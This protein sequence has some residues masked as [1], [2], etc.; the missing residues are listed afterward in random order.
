MSPWAR[1][2]DY[3]AVVALLLAAAAAAAGLL[4]SGL[5]RDTA[6]MVRQA[7]ATDLVTLAV[8]L[9]AL[10][11][12]LWRARSGSATARLV[13]IGALG[14]MAYSYA[15]YGFSVVINPLT[16]VHLAILGLATWALVL[17][18]FGLDQAT[19][20]RAGRIR[21][22]RRTT[23]GFLVIVTALFGLLWLGQ[24]AGAITSGKLPPS[25][26]ELNLPTSAIYALDLAFALPLLALAGGW[27]LRHDRRGP[28]SALAAL[29]WLVLL[30]LSVLAIFAID[31]AAGVSVESVPV[32]VFGVVTGVAAV[33]AVLGILSTRL[34]NAAGS[35]VESAS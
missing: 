3:L 7:R 6:E 1:V 30:G 4:G 10:G 28:A 33:L 17:T 22:P 16:P 25:V 11:L 8:V 32:V 2:A 5:Y 14:Y 24:I 19:V 12:G 23:G 26:I 18:V 31:A 20:D 34:G 21:L 9:P 27:L 15:I 35:P 29:F 13:A